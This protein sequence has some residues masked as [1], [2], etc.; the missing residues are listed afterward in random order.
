MKCRITIPLI[1][2]GALLVAALS[3]GSPVFLAGAVLLAL[4]MAVGL[5][6][7]LWAAGTMNV[8]TDLSGKT[9]TRGEKVSMTVRL[10]HK[11]LLPI[12]PIQLEL[13]ATPETPETTLRLSDAPGRSQTLEL[14]FHAMHVGVSR[15]GIRAVTVEDLFGLFS[16]RWTP[17]AQLGELLV[18]PM[19]FKVDELNFAPGD[20]GLGTMARATEDISSPSDVRTYQPGDPMKKIHWKLSVRK[21]E[22]MVRKFEEPVIQAAVALMDCARPPFHKQ[23]EAHADVRDT[24]LETA[25]SVIAAQMR[26]EHNIRLPLMGKHPVEVDKRMGMPLVLENLARA[27]FSETDRFDR[28]LQLEMRRMRQVG[29]VVVI[30]ARLTGD[31]VEVM[32][33]MRRMGPTVR[34]YYV[35]FEPEAPAVLPFIARLQ[36][37]TV[38]VC[39]VK[40]MKA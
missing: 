38:E 20:A 14:P 31:V 5:A 22:L 12:A 35:T 3:T 18:L 28:V 6:S 37:A 10:T 39:Y 17:K 19:T 25:A 4:V 13:D 36:Q 33:R 26:T 40:P 7:V 23:E 21:N 16:K 24:L 15:P 30:T 32:T 8:A 27:D 1:C 34:L 9:V 2:L 11:C 29:A